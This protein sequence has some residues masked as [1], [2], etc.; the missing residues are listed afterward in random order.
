MPDF[1]RDHL[2]SQLFVSL[3][4]MVIVIHIILG[5][6]TLCIYAERKISAYIQDRIGPNRTGFDFGLPFLGFLRGFLGLGQALAD[7]LKFFLKEDYRPT[8]VDKVLFTLAPAI[9]IVPAFIGFMILPW[10]GVWDMPRMDLPLIGPIGGERVLVAGA[11]V[12]VGV[13]YLLAVASLGAYGITLGGWASNNKYSF[14]GGLRATAQMIS[15]EIPLGLALLTALLVLGTFMPEHIVR[16]QADHGWLVLSMPLAAILFYVCSLAEANRAPFDNAEAEQ[17]LVGGYHTEYSS[18]RFALFFLAEYSHLVVGSA[19]FA[20]F[21]LGGYH[22]PGVGL[23]DPAAT[24]FLAVLIKFAV[25]FTKACLLVILAMVVRWTLPRMRYDQI[26]Q[27]GWQSL[28][29]MGM[30][31]LVVISFMI[32]RG[33]TNPF[34]LFLANALVFV[35]VLVV[36]PIMARAFGRSTANRR[37]PMYGSRFHPVPGTEVNTR[38]TDPMALED[39]PV[40]GTVSTA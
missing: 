26:M 39:R 16:W 37:I 21:F 11:D 8:N 4:V 20:L 17:E 23:T 3:H 14:L 29:P 15:Y 27:L 6:V 1:I 7:G 25:F 22:L 35:G 24:S 18:M 33:W 13:V 12:H 10:G 38:P 40:Q 5:T 9:V 34:A 36:Q 2:S 30:V 31:L 19:F 28:I 32:Y